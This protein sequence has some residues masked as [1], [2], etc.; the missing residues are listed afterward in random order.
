MFKSI[1]NKSINNNS[2]IDTSKLEK[3]LKKIINQ[4]NSGNELILFNKLE[5]FGKLRKV[6][7]E[8]DLSIFLK[9]II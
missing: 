3:I 4:K 7:S 6:F 5:T 1:L 8:N 2:K 9:K